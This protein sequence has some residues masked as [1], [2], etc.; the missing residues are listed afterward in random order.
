MRDVKFCGK[1]FKYF[2]QYSVLGGFG[3]GDFIF[4]S[5]VKPYYFCFK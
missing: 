3:F 2:Y 4:I 5:L 1:E